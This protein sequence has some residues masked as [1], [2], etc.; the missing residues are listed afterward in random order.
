MPFLLKYTIYL[1]RITYVIN[2]LLY[3]L[4]CSTKVNAH[5]SSSFVL[6]VKLYSF[7]WN[8]L[9]LHHTRFSSHSGSLMM[10]VHLSCLL[11]WTAHQ[12]ITQCGWCRRLQSAAIKLPLIIGLRLLHTLSPYIYMFLNVR[13]SSW[14]ILSCSQKTT[15][16]GF[17]YSV[18]F[19]IG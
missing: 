1:P 7:R 8:L 19:L 2:A 15:F 11:H 5:E 18:L 14:F 13:L 9:W 16:W 4:M 12:T 6:T 10:S 17:L 3:L